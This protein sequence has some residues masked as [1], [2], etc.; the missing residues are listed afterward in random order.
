MG[1]VLNNQKLRSTSFRFLGFFFFFDDLLFWGFY[2]W[3]SLLFLFLNSLGIVSSEIEFSLKFFFLICII[4]LHGHLQVPEEEEEEER[5][6]TWK[7]KRS[8]ANSTPIWPSP[9][10]GGSL[11]GNLV[12]LLSLF[13]LVTQKSFT[14]VERYFLFSILP[15]DFS[16]FYLFPVSPCIHLFFSFFFTFL[17]S[18]P[19]SNLP[20]ILTHTDWLNFYFILYRLL[21]R[22]RKYRGHFF[23]KKR[24]EKSFCLFLFYFFFC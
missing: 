1:C 17:S 19:P 9:C 23:H 22:R 6:R 11:V 24:R 21:R 20:F 15:L 4:C 12:L 16:I 10:T 13:S 18:I 7:R 8:I 14:E 3:S 5:R 2:S